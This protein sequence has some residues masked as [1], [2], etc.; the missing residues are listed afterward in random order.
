MKF[1]IIQD[2]KLKFY[3]AD[4][5]I[6]NENL[7]L[8]LEYMSNLPILYKEA[9]NVRNRKGLLI[10]RI[11]KRGVYKYLDVVTFKNRIFYFDGNRLGK[12]KE[13]EVW[14]FYRATGTCSKKLRKKLTK[15]KY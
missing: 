13:R 5:S 1:K 8:F 12:R 11:S 3:N 2:P 9:I 10:S 15:L 4:G 6:R 14:N 7:K